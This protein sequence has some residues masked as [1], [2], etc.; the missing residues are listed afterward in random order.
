MKKK[1]QLTLF[2]VVGIVIVVAIVAFFMIPKDFGGKTGYSEDV[3]PIANFIQNC[4]EDVSIE[5]IPAV[6]KTGGF[7]PN[8]PTESIMDIPYYVYEGENRMPTKDQLSTSISNYID[9]MVEDCLNNY[10]TFKDYNILPGEKSSKIEI[11]KED[12][13]I[14]YTYKHTIEKDNKKDTIGSFTFEIPS[15]LG[16]LYD[17]AEYLVNDQLPLQS[18]TCLNCVIDLTKTNSVSI[19]TTGLEDGTVI[20]SIK[21]ETIE[22]ENPLILLF[23]F[24]GGKG[25]N[26]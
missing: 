5:S 9:E 14:Q 7:Y 4:L 19:I 3:E 24:E 6:S 16:I 11:G 10:E 15:R 8:P 2:I 25:P 22:T 21:D 18:G 1:G 23:A 20:Y 13:I 26:V 12:I 17:S